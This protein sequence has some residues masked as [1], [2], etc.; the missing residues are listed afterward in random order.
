MRK[1]TRRGLIKKLDTLF[2]AKVREIGFCQHCG[3]KN[4]LQCAHIFS[5]KNL[6]VRW[7]PENAVCF[8]YRCHFYWAHRNPIEYT[9]WV[10]QF[11]DIGVLQ[12]R[13]AHAKPIK[14]FDLEAKLVELTK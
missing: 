3:S 9:E 10:K 14:M 8:C 6:S 5:R 4:N 12:F 1:I 2:A 13:I 11:K 7:D